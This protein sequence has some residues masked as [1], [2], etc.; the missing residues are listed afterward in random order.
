V[1]AEVALEDTLELLSD[2]KALKERWR[3]YLAQHRLNT[4]TQREAIVDAINRHYGLTE[5]ESADSPDEGAESLA[6]GRQIV[7][8]Q[9]GKERR[10]E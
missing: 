8:R 3:G 7:S 1:S 2:P 9:R 5:G 6:Q 10:T 4:T